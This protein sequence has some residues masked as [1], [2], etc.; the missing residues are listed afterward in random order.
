LTLFIIAQMTRQM[1]MGKFFS[2][3]L[4]VGITSSLLFHQ[5]KHEPDDVP[6]PG[7]G[8]TS[9]V[10]DTTTNRSDTCNFDTLYFVNDILPIFIA[11]CVSSGCHDAQSAK[12]GIILSNYND[13]IK[14]GKIKAFDPNAG[15]ILEVLTETDPKKVMPPP[16]AAKLPAE[17]VNAIRIWINQGALNNE[18]RNVCDTTKVTFTTEIWPIVNSTCKGCHSGSRPSGGVSI[19]NYDQVKS[20]VNN[21]QLEGTI[22]GKAGFKRMPPGGSVDQCSL[23]KIAIWIKAGAPNN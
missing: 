12:E 14:T 3:M 16:P 6:E 22:F 17:L 7:N 9:I 11:N 23:D 21:G 18:C 15:D 4:L 5:C 13:I 2:L 10:I 8:D 20:L 19:T 1:K